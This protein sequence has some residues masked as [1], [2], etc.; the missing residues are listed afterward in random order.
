MVAAIHI[1]T[2]RH[3]SPLFEGRIRHPRERKQAAGVHSHSQAVSSPAGSRT[4]DKGSCLLCPLPSSVHVMRSRRLF[5][6][7]R[8]HTRVGGEGNG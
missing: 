8:E 3:C 1:H 5:L 4:E 2:P 7:T 6:R